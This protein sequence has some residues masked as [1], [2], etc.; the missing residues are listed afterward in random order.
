MKE[1]TRCL[2]YFR[3]AH[4]L[5]SLNT[6]QVPDGEKFRDQLAGLCKLLENQKAFAEGTT[7]LTP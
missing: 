2:N 1:L 4:E 6:M 7:K 5:V 3:L